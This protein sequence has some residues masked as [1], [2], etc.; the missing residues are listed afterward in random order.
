MVGK[1]PSTKFDWDRNPEQFTHAWTDH[2]DHWKT[3]NITNET[4]FQQVIDE[5][6]QNGRKVIYKQTD[7]RGNFIG[8]EYGFYEEARNIFVAAKEDGRLW[9]AFRPGTNWNQPGAGLNYVMT[10]KWTL[11]IK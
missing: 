3:L 8:D 11:E 1:F 5:V 7:N 9:T 4:Q 6:I 10:R 2:Q